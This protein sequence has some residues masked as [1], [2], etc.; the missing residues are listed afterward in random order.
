MCEQ[1]KIFTENGK[2]YCPEST[3]YFVFCPFCGTKLVLKET[4]RTFALS[5]EDRDKFR[6]VYDLGMI[7]YN[8]NLNPDDYLDEIKS[9]LKWY[10]P[11]I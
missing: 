8:K 4:F 2:Y 9:K 3:D 7:Y 5:I 11:K 10:K 6:E 1:C